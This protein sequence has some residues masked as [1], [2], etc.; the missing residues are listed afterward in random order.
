MAAAKPDE[1]NEL[2][3]LNELP[4]PPPLTEDEFQSLINMVEGN[5]LLP[6]GSAV[7]V[8]VGDI[9]REGH[10]IHTN[11]SKRTFA[12]Y[13]D[14]GIPALLVN[15][16]VGVVELR[17]KAKNLHL[18]KYNV[19]ILWFNGVLNQYKRQYKQTP[20]Y[21]T[22]EETYNT[23]EETKTEGDDPPPSPPPPPL[24]WVWKVTLRL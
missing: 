21:K 5:N 20:A 4:E 15:V 17:D 24:P 3:Q 12:I 8:S 23:W 14:D 13:F 6:P 19:M 1:P 10:I 16:P 7:T 9:K 18:G 2:D 22:W 11:I